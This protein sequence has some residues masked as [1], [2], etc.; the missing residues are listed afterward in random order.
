[1]SSGELSVKEARVASWSEI[2]S[3]EAR[4]VHRDAVDPGPEAG[5]AAEAVDGPEDT[6]ED[7]LREV[8]RF[9]T[10]AE[11]VHRELHH[12]AL[13]LGH[14]LGAG[15]FISRRAA[16]HERRF[17]TVDVRPAGDACLRH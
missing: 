12:H 10:I 11:Q 2:D 13:V 1:M 16:L 15:E 7:F 5:L 8:E 3:A 17:A 14:E 9:V 6:Q 4:L